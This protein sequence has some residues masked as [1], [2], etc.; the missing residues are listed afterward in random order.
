MDSPVHSSIAP[1]DLVSV[2]IPAYNAA[3]FLAAAVES[4]LEQTHRDIEVIIVDDGSRDDTWAIAR[5]ASEQDARV[6]VFR[7]ENRG[8][9]AARN[10]AIA[11]ASGRYIAP[12]D[13][14]DVWHRRKLELQLAAIRCRNGAACAYTWMFDID[15][16]D[17]VSRISVEGLPGKASF[18]RILFYR[19]SSVARVHP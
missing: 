16:N 10:L 4:A 6:R 7:Q 12:L 11:N 17:W 14:D 5:T 8:V 19:T 1:D 15:E 3:Q 9:A 18:C 2:V 13:A